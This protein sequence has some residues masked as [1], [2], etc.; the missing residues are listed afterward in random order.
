MQESVT[1]T[2]YALMGGEAAVLS[3]VDRFY[4]YMDTLPEVLGLRQMHAASL[5][6]AKMKLF[7]FLS[8]WLGG[9]GLFEQ[10]YGHPRLRQRH[11]PFA[12]GEAEAEQWMLCMNKALDEV[13][14][15]PALR[16]AIRQALTQLAGHMVNQ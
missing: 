14:M 8:G 2:P 15:D 16:D 6:S 4:F 7:K 12:I 10:E 3:L 11:F 13:A 5:A 9:P 1:S